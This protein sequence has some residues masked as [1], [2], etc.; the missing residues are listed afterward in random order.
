MSMKQIAPDVKEVSAEDMEAHF[1]AYRVMNAVG[2]YDAQFK[3]RYTRLM[4]A[5]IEGLLPKYGSWLQDNC[6]RNNASP[7]GKVMIPFDFNSLQYGL[8]QMD[9]TGMSGL[10]LFNGPLAVFT[11]AAECVDFMALRAREQGYE[12][13]VD[14]YVQGYLLSVVHQNA[15]LAGYRT[16]DTRRLCGEFMPLKEE[17]KTRREELEAIE[18]PVSR[19]VRGS[20]LNQKVQQLN[21]AR[22][23]FHQA[24]DEI[25]YQQTACVQTLRG[26]NGVVNRIASTRQDFED[27]QYIEGFISHNTFGQRLQWWMKVMY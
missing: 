9:E 23:T 14:E 22:Q 7:D 6:L 18:E 25:D 17:V 2:V 16:Q 12:K 8:R 5:K 4:G 19:F 15:L 1:W 13:D 26:W 21:A 27:A 10:Y 11:S 24:F 3:E 20:V